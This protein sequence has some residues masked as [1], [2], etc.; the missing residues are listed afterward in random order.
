MKS[1]WLFSGVAVA[2]VFLA[3]ASHAQGKADPKVV[4]EC[5]TMWG[6]PHNYTKRTRT[7]MTVRQCVAEKSKR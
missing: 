5:Q 2:L 6:G 4:A 1:L 3:D 7:G